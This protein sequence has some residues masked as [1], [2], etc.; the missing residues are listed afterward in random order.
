MKFT[1]LSK[2][3]FPIFRSITGNG[4]RESLKIIQ[5]QIPIKINEISSGEKV[6]DWE[7]PKEWNIDD[8]FIKNAKGEKIVDFQKSNLHVV[9]YSVPINGKY[10]LD[11]LKKTSTHITK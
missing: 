11:E 2:K 4:V 3:L 7:I 5:K 9:N 6:F 8:A 1:I 10:T